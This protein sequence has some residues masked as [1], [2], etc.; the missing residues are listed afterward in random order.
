MKRAEH[1]PTSELTVYAG[2][3]CKTWSVADA[4][5]LLPQHSHEFPHL[6]LIV[7]GSVQVWRDDKDIG[8]YHAPATVRIPAHTFHK[9]MTLTDGVVIACIHAVGDADAVVVAREHT[10]EM[11]D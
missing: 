2:I 5:T 11:E 7:R 10:L 8:D 6:S 1:Q 3:F 4:G 9:F